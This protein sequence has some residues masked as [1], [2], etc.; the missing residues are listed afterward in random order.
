VLPEDEEPLLDAMARLAAANGLG[1]GPET[2]YVGSFR[3]HGVLVPVWDLPLDREVA[4]LEQP[5]AE[6]R[7]RLD[8]ALASPRPLT[9][10]QRRSRAGLL[11]RQLT[12][13]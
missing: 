5:A 11:S 1:L 13:N 8:E 2:R 12:L 7:A 6:L 9:G 4:D 10:E 3:A